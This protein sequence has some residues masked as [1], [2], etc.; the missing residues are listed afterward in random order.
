MLGGKKL[1]DL[2]GGLKQASDGSL[3]LGDNLKGLGKAAFGVIPGLGGWADETFTVKSAQDDAA[4]ATAAATAAAQEQAAQAKAT[5][6]A[7][8]L[9][10]NA[11]LASF[12][13][14]LAYE[15]AQGKTTKAIGEYVA[16][17][18]EAG[19]RRRYAAPT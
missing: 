5:Q 3:S 17:A 19:Q 15:D 12:N 8:E 7:I 6:D 2:T 13:S 18:V 14:Q 9:L 4:E 10:T 16:A 1:T 11:V